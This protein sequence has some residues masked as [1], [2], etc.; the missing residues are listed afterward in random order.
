MTHAL[1]YPTNQKT[2]RGTCD[3][4]R[5]LSVPQPCSL[6]VITVDDPFWAKLLDGASAAGGDLVRLRDA[7]DSARTLHQFKPIAV[8]LDLDHPS[9]W[10]AVDSLL[11]NKNAPPLL[12]ATSRSGQVD[13][14][15]AIEAGVLIDKR[16]DPVM[17]LALAESAHEDHHDR[18]AMQRLLIRWLK[19]YSAPVHGPPLRRY[20]G[21]NEY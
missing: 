18:I 1:A 17:V 10:T 4:R 16:S 14:K 2:V 7:N 8:L 11:Q 12:L 5:E 3:R 6:L 19:P 15:T 20:W 13:F 9:A 21:I